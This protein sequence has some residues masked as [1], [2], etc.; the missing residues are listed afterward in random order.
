[1]NPYRS[2]SDDSDSDTGEEKLDMWRS[3]PNMALQD[4]REVLEEEDKLNQ[5]PNRDSRKG[6]YVENVIETWKVNYIHY[7]NEILKNL[8]DENFNSWVTDTIN[9]VNRDLDLK[10][11]FQNDEVPNDIRRRLELKP[12]GLDNSFITTYFIS[13][14]VRHYTYTKLKESPLQSVIQ[15]NYFDYK[16]RLFVRYLYYKIQS[17]KDYKA[18]TI[19]RLSDRRGTGYLDD[20]TRDN[21]GDFIAESKKDSSGV[22]PNVS[23]SFQ[24]KS[25]W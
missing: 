9:K 12:F 3:Y 7:S 20:D 18:F 21:V 6:K 1:M 24:G 13:W 25:V 8:E 2:S 17:V 4:V 23:S 11:W 14:L 5:L 16:H 19:A 10:D 15:Y 22:D